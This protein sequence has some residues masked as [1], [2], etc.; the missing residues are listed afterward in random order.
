[1]KKIEVI[2]VDDHSI[3]LDGITAMFIENPDIEIKG[4][5]LNGEELIKQ[6]KFLVPNVI[7][8]D[9]TLPNITGIEICKIISEQ[10]PSI[11]ILIMSAKTD[12]R[13]ITDSVKSGAKGFLPKNAK[14]DEIEKAIKW[15]NAGKIYFGKG[16]SETVFKGNVKDLSEVKFPCQN[17][18]LTNRQVEV[19]K[20]FSDGL[21]YK[22]I[23]Y[24]LDISIKTVE[25]HKAKIM[26]K[27]EAK[28]TAELV[29]YAI[30][31]GI[32]TLD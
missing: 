8:L 14:K 29:K 7:L 24:Q 32:T 27:I 1:M 9:I 10:Y 4:A 25:A 2:V 13:S 31:E 11:A 23:A 17:T 18:S 3:V 26:K 6:L 30:R 19:V 15:V 22:E 21:L 20:L 12:E 28:S 5:F 16:I